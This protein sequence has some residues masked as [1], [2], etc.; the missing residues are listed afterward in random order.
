MIFVC[1]CCNNKFCLQHRL[2]EV[3][4]CK[5]DYSKKELLLKNLEKIECQKIDKI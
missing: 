3:H 2:P 4:L 5:S 1:E